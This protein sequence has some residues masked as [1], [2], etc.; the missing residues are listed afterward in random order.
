M[1]VVEAA[2]PIHSP[3]LYGNRL[4]QDIYSAVQT[5]TGSP[6]TW[7]RCRGG[8]WGCLGTSQLNFK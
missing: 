7:A 3:G 8:G 1:V 5:Q 4:L 6:N 2:I